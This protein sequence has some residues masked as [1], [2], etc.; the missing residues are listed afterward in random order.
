MSGVALGA[1]VWIAPP[2]LATLIVGCPVGANRFVMKFAKLFCT[3]AVASVVSLTSCANEQESII[4][5]GAP[6]WSMGCGVDSPAD[7]F[8]PFGLLDLRFGT[9][10]Y[11]PVEIQNQLQSQQPDSTNSGTDNSEFQLIDAE[12]KLS[13]TQRPDI[14]DALDQENSALV[15]FTQPVAAESLP[16]A[17][18]K[19]IIVEVIPA[20]TAARISAVRVAEATDAGAAAEAQFE[21]E[22]PDASDAQLVEARR[23]GEEAVLNQEL[24][25]VVELSINARR[26]GNKVGK[27]GEVESRSFEFPI[28]VCYGC[29]VNCSSCEVAFDNDGDGGIDETIVGLCPPNVVPDEPTTP[30]RINDFLAHPCNTAQDVLAI[31]PNVCT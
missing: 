2:R 10:Y 14:I 9:G 7:T 29:L 12:I 28:R 17:S 1:I 21:I 15:E 23:Q 6:T 4:I 31:P 5:T 16:G 22:N 27:V 19:G 11:L 26:T 25:V 24:T 20:A 18:S 13:M 30:L 8:L 3:A